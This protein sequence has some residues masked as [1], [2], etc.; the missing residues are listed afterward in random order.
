MNAATHV[1]FGCGICAPEGWLNF[2]IS[3]RLSIERLPLVGN[4]M[5]SAGKAIFPTGVL[6]GDI[7]AGLPVPDGSAVAVYSS[8]TLEHLAKDDLPVALRNTFR[9]MAPGGVFRL[10][11]PD[12][13]WRAERYVRALANGAAAAAD[14]AAESAAD[15][16]L[17]SALLGQDRRDRSL[18][19]KARQLVGN[20]HHLWMYDFATMKA[21]LEAAGF[22]DVR[23]CAFGDATDPKFA[24]VEARNR[25]E[26]EG[27][28]ELAIE[29]RKPGGK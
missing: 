19:G 9:M 21:R 20:S 27:H 6:K 25:F 14:G 26:D 13:Q 22:V 10:I 11:V 17:S 1:Q 2:D 18:V 16:F 23:R 4:V 28:Q 12:L 7:V 8:H 24:A 15:Q 5:R 3:P 29:C